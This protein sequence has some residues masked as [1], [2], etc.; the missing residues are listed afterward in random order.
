MLLL[1]L[2]LPGVSMIINGRIIS[3]I[4]A[5]ILQ[6]IACFTFLVFGIGF[7]LWLIIAIWAV[8]VRSSVKTERKLKK[9]EKRIMNSQ[10]NI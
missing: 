8:N 7:I 6:V 5:L 4:I 9:M 1:A 10:N 2:V 3:G